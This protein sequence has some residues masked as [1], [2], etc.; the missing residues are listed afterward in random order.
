MTREEFIRIE[1]GEG[2]LFIHNDTKWFRTNY[3]NSFSRMD[4]YYTQKARQ[5]FIDDS[6]II[7]YDNVRY[8]VQWTVDSEELMKRALWKYIKGETKT[9][10]ML[11][12]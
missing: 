3:Y 9:W 8:Y 7:D 1:K 10:H 11:E 5:D 6:D 12:S 4:K 2:C